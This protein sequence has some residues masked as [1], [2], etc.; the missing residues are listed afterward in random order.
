MVLQASPLF[1]N[2]TDQTGKV[3]D[4]FKYI[5]ILK[6]IFKRHSFIIKS[7]HLSN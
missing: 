7:E 1:A 3:T 5:F 6:H 4:L 2:V